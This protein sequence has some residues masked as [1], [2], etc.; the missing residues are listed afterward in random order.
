[1]GL[2]IRNHR[3]HRFRD[4]YRGVG[5]PIPKGALMETLA[6]I[7]LVWLFFGVL[8]MVV[9]P[10]V[11]YHILWPIWNRVEEW[12]FNRELDRMFN[13]EVKRILRKEEKNETTD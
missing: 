4:L 11:S 5:R 7:A 1:M 10:L 6:W 13:R 3:H 9:I 12:L 8:V 2:R